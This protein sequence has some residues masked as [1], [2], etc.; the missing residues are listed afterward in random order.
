MKSY[1]NR[2]INCIYLLLLACCNLFCNIKSDTLTQ[3]E[4]VDRL[5]SENNDSLA[6]DILQKI[7]PPTDTTYELALY[8]YLIAKRNMRNDQTIESDFLDYSIRTFKENGDSLRLSYSYNYKSMS[9]FYDI[10][11]KDARRYNLMAET[12]AKNLADPLLDYNIYSNGFVIAAYHYDT[13]ECLSYAQKAY[14]VGLKLGD[15]KRMAYPAMYLTMC[16]NEKNMADSAKKYM[17]LCLNYI[18]DYDDFTKSDVYKI[19]GDVLAKSDFAM[20]ERYYKDAIAIRNNADAFNGLTSLYLKHNRMLQADSCYKKALRHKA[21]ET[22]IKLM[23]DYVEMLEKI[24]EFKKAL[25][26]RN[27]MYQSLDSLREEMVDGLEERINNQDFELHRNRASLLLMEHKVL[28]YQCIVGGCCVIIVILCIILYKK[29]VQHNIP[30]VVTSD[31]YLEEEQFMTSETNNSVI[32][33][34]ETKKGELILE[35]IKNNENVSQLSKDDRLLFVRYYQTI[36]SDFFEQLEKQYSYKN[37][38]VN[39]LIILILQHLGKDKQSITDILK[40]SDQ[41]FRSHKSRINSQK[42]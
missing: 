29:H 27:Q 21:Y 15:E 20:A 7:T 24:G 6:V 35:K 30:N 18:D 11:K 39:A 23:G 36:A 33:D 16:F 28:V 42:I 12:A 5:F 31:E 32:D 40:I 17:A 38:S 2:N 25:N 4:S 3:L 26:I 8:N 22:N 9:F 34:D 10:N 19:F 41:A 1:I 14:N 13:N 37:L